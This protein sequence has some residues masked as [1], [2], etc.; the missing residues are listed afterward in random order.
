MKWKDNGYSTTIME[1]GDKFTVHY[2]GCGHTTKDG[3][4][5]FEGKWKFVSGT[6]KLKGL[7]GGG[8]YKGSGASD[9]SGVVEVEGEYAF[10]SAGAAKPTSTK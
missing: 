5:V 1:N 2:L 6:G 7:K 10:K 9:G 3:G 8:T 4:G